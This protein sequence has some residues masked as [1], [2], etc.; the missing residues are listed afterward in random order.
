MTPLE[1]KRYYSSEEF[2]NKYIYNEKDLG[3]TYLKDKTVFKLM[4]TNSS[5]SCY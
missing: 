2:K 4:G 1:L 5:R 3:I